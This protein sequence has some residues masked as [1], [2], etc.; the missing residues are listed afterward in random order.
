MKME[1][2]H[3]YPE[4]GFIRLPRN[5]NNFLADYMVAYHSTLLLED[6]DFYIVT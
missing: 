5:V 1:A 2:L 4:D 6:R 3:M